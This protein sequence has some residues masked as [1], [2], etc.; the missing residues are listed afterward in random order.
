[1]SYAVG[2]ANYQ[3]LGQT[4]WIALVPECPK[5][6]PHRKGF[7]VLHQQNIVVSTYVRING[8]SSKVTQTPQGGV[9]GPNVLHENVIHKS[10]SLTGRKLVN[11]FVPVSIAGRRR[12]TFFGRHVSKEVFKM[13]SDI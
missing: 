8:L 13:R 4:R 1:M 3:L 10:R 5:T 9:G 11:L 12:A 6:V 2:I 7:I